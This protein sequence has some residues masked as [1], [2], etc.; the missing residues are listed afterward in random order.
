MAVDLMRIAEQYGRQL[1]CARTGLEL[2]DVVLTRALDVGGSPR[3]VLVGTED[4]KTALKGCEAF[5]WGLRDFAAENTNALGAEGESLKQMGVAIGGGAT[6]ASTHAGEGTLTLRDVQQLEIDVH[7]GVAAL[8]EF[9]DGL[10]AV[11]L[12]TVPE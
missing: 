7:A 8:R 4:L 10:P 9:V 6:T 5:G 3:D 12:P 11:N 1:A 2:A